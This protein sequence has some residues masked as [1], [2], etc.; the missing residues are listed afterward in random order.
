M[1][2]TDKT[3]AY[4]GWR[5]RCKDF[6]ELVNQNIEPEVNYTQND[7]YQWVNKNLTQEQTSRLI[8]AVENENKE[9]FKKNLNDFGY[10][11][12]QQADWEED[13]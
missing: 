4:L 13:K 3:L 1:K 12:K 9:L 8:E 11:F 2:P 5:M 6:Y 10:L 7:F